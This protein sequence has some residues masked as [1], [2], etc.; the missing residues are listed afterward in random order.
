MLEWHFQPLDH[1]I[2]INP[3][4]RLGKSQPSPSLPPNSSYSGEPQPRCCAL[5]VSSSFQNSKCI[6]S[7]KCSRD[8]PWQHFFFFFSLAISE[9]LQFPGWQCGSRRLPAFEWRC[10]VVPTY[11][12]SLKTSWKSTMIFKEVRQ[13]SSKALHICSKTRSFM[14]SGRPLWKKKNHQLSIHYLKKPHH[15]TI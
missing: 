2:T 11:K 13:I 15:W 1:K 14:P 3:S 7:H 5:V 12:S 6:F 8:T 4:E 10:P 9:H